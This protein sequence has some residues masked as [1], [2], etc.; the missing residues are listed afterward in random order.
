ME[1]E[2]GLGVS[3]RHLHLCRKDM[4]IL[5]GKGSELTF[6]KPISQPGQF[7]SNEQVILRTSKGDTKLR[8]LG[9]LRP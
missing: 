7:A 8:V 4:D 6:K 2:I 9:P 5:F 3:A 1:F